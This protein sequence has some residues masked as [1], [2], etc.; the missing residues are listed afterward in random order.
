MTYQRRFSTQPC[1]DGSHTLVIEAVP[2]V[3]LVRCDSSGRAVGV[4]VM[5]PKYRAGKSLM[6][7]IRDMHVYRDAILGKYGERLVVGAA[8][9]APRPGNLPVIS[10]DLPTAFPAAVTA[11]PGHDPQVFKRLL[12]AAIKTLS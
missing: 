12:G 9:L 2:D 3:T 5:D 7:G 1:A 6:D 10:A 11:R 8:I 4:V